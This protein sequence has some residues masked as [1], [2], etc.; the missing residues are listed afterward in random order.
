M[1]DTKAIAAIRMGYIISEFSKRRVLWANVR[2]EGG[3]CWVRL[4]IEPVTIVVRARCMIASENVVWIGDPEA[5]RSL[6]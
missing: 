1:E 4:G 2:V 3:P 5:C 6:V